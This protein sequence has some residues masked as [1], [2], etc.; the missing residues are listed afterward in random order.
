MALE[1]DS[2]PTELPL[3]SRYTFTLVNA[4]NMVSN[5]TSFS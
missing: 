2:V 5:F 3:C 1:D 4:G